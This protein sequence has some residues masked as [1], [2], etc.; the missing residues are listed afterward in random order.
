MVREYKPIKM[1]EWE[2]FGGGFL[3]KSFYK[4]DDDSVM[5]KLYEPYFDEKE[6]I[7]EHYVAIAV[8]NCGIK[9]PACYGLA[10]S[11]DGRKGILFQR[12]KNK[13]SFARLCGN[14]PEKA[15]EYGEIF[16][17][18]AKVLHSTKCNTE[19][20]PSRLS[21]MTDTIRN[22]NYFSPEENEKIIEYFENIQQ[23]DTCLHG[24]FHFGNMIQA[25]GE[26]LW[27]DL[28]DFSYGDPRFDIAN[29]MF[30][31]VVGT[32]EELTQSMF[33]CDKE[34][35]LAFW[36]GLLKSYAGADTEEKVKAYNE[37]LMPFVGMVVFF[38]VKKGKPLDEFE[39]GVLHKCLDP[40]IK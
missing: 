35:R 11:D 21:V 2:E 19:I 10:Q 28:G 16:G 3:C 36:S 7:E 4:K 32:N 27:I 24:D 1:A 38:F 13:T 15:F 22:S 40:I 12:V 34:T 29:Q 39:L 14:N 9:S 23:P 18:E 37:E 8:K 6:I 17:R 20:F 30:S 33:H 25:E 5:L 31:C 26:N